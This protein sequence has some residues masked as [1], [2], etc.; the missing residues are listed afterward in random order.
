[1][2]TRWVI[3]VLGWLAAAPILSAQARGGDGYLFSPPHATFSLR[4]GYARASASSD[5]FAFVTE[6][7]TVDRG[8]FSGLEASLLGGQR[9]DSGGG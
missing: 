6:R 3:G 9:D 2:R 7:L 4:G 1:M 8:D 5:V